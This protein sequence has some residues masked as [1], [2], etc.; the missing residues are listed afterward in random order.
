MAWQ[1]GIKNKAK[2]RASVAAPPPDP[3]PYEVPDPGKPIPYVQAIPDYAQNADSPN[4]I[5]PMGQQLNWVDKG[6]VPTGD[7]PSP[8]APPQEWHGYERWGDY[9][10]SIEGEHLVNGRE[11]LPLYGQHRYAAALN[12][13]W[14]R[15]PDTRPQRAPH[16]WDFERLFDQGVLGERNLNGSHYSAANIGLTDNPSTSLKGMSPTRRRTSTFRLEPVQYGENTVSQA[17]RIG[18]PSAVF[19]SPGY[20]FNTSSGSYRLS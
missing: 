20:T 17:A 7:R 1:W 2:R 15:I 19:T 4:Y 8:K 12:P 5:S 9:G 18:P 14:Y 3:R 10:R 16:E 11:G 6:N 13:Y